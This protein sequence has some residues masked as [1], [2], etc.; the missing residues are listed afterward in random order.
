M[1]RSVLTVILPLATPAAVYLLW[2]WNARRRAEAR[3]ETE[4]PQ[5][6]DAPWVTLAI[7]GLILVIGVLGTLALFDG[8]PPG[9]TYVPPQYVDGE[10]IPGRLEPAETT[11]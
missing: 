9:S 7:A 10:I 5:L 2:H 1:F 8:A 4:I 11:E 3:G 6:G